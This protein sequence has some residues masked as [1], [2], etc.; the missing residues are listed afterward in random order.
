M[1]PWSAD[2]D[3]G[4]SWSI[5]PLDLHQQTV[6]ILVNASS[7]S[8]FFADHPPS[9]L[10]LSLS[11]LAILHALSCFLLFT[12]SSVLV[13]AVRAQAGAVN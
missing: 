9:N 2:V 13:I 8:T 3:H 5:G 12:V 1:R 11:Y 7:T 4:E 6:P 10:S